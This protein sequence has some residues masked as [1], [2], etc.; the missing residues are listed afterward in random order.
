[1]RVLSSAYL[2]KEVVTVSGVDPGLGGG[3]CLDLLAIEFHNLAGQGQGLRTGLQL[4]SPYSN[5]VTCLLQ[6]AK[7]LPAPQQVL[8]ADSLPISAGQ[9]AACTH[10]Q[11]LLV[12]LLPQSGR[13]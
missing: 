5:G 1:M 9:A 4:C 8:S 11:V 7:L 3:P 10:C 2:S 6:L 13:L 12:D